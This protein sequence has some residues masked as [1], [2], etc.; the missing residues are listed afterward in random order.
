[1]KCASLLAIAALVALAAASPLLDPAWTVH[2]PFAPA[3]NPTAAVGGNNYFVEDINGTVWSID[4]ATHKIQWSL[5]WDDITSIMAYPD[6]DALVILLQE[7]TWTVRASTGELLWVNNTVQPGASAVAAGKWL[8]GFVAN[9]AGVAELAC[10]DVRTGA[11]H[12]AVP[13]ATFS[14][15]TPI[16]VGTTVIVVNGT[17][18]STTIMAF[19]ADDG[20]L[21]WN[22]P[23]GNIVGAGNGLLITLNQTNQSSVNSDLYLV[24]PATGDVKAHYPNY[25]SSQT[26]IAT[27]DLNGNIILSD[28]Y[29]FISAVDSAT[30]KLLWYQSLSQVQ[31]MPFGVKQLLLSNTGILAVSNANSTSQNQLFNITSFRRDTG[32]VK[33]TI[34]MPP[35]TATNTVLCLGA[36][37]FVPNLIGYTAWSEATGALVS[38][39]Y[40]GAIPIVPNTQFVVGTNTLVAQTPDGSVSAYNF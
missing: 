30:Y 13:S 21:A 20:S 34:V 10:Y 25:T 4:V 35:T 37:I 38:K 36:Y 40:S 1:M 31:S 8:V 18:P 33:W 26:V 14:T 9:G 19:N 11:L 24:D 27:F 2:L 39:S 29:N 5:R 7:G 32:A 15:G 12:W 6:Q 17:F 16:A 28:S 22:K 23:F 3:A